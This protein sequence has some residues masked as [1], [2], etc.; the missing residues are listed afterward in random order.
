MTDFH[1]LVLSLIDGIS[2]SLIEQ[3]REVV[4]KIL[5]DD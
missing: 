4:S 3:G 2:K 1:G 5:T